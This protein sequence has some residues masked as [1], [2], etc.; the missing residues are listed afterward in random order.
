MKYI[1][2]P[3]LANNI[4]MKD[5]D[6]AKSAIDYLNQVLSDKFVDSK[7]DYVFIAPKTSPK[8]LK[9]AI[10][11]YVNIGKLIVQE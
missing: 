5:F 6:D 9:K 1:A 10:E 7:F 4:G 8:Q 3:K 11:D 2:K